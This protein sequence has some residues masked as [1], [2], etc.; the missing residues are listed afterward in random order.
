M[1]HTITLS[2]VGKTFTHQD[3]TCTLFNDVF[4]VFEQSK[5]YALV[6]PSG[7]GKTTLLSMIAG[8]EKVSSGSIQYN[9]TVLHTLSVQELHS[10]CSTNYSIMLQRPA[11]LNECTL[12]ENVMLKSFINHTPTATDKQRA[13]E[14][15]SYVGLLECASR[16]PKNLSGGEAQRVAIAQALFS[17]PHFIIADEPTAHVDQKNKDCIINLLINAHITENIGIILST[18]D[19]HVA[20]KMNIIYTLQ[21]TSYGNSIEKKI[22]NS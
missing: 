20:N 7:S 16:S 11:L 18:H 9:E 17:R 10:F 15:L 4:M 13:Y 5:T 1:N 3:A 14:L 6:G 19:I 21:G 8:L 22:N 2:N 12:L